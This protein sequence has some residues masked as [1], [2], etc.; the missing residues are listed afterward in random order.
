[1]SIT[2]GASTF[3]VTA[4][5]G[6]LQESSEDKTIEIATIRNDLGKTIIAQEKPR[7]QTITTVKTKSDAALLTVPTSGEFTGATV[8]SSKMSQTNDDFSMSEATYTLHE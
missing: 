1:M 7:S 8:T 6:Y 3:G 4:P 5:S 2:F